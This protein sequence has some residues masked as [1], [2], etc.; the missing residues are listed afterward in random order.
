[1]DTISIQELTVSTRI[2]VYA[3]EKQILQPLRIDIHIPV[4][5][6][7]VQ[8]DLTKTVDY[9]TV[10]KF[11]TNYVETQ[12]FQLVETLAHHL[13]LAIKNE[14]HLDSLSITIQKPQAIKST[15]TVS[16]TVHR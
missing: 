1:M 6:S 12:N 13:A 2:G 10:C 16:I 4:D 15:R 11:T 3:W 5:C 9:E 14:F 8:D 7:K